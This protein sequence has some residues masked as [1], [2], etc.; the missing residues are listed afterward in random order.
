M[1]KKKIIIISIIA[2]VVIAA[3]AGVLIYFGVQKS[4]NNQAELTTNLETLGKSFY[5]DFYYPHQ[6]QAIE[7][8]NAKLK[9]KETPSTIE[10][11]LKNYEK[12]GI[13]VNLENISK[14]SSVDKNLVDS[15][16]NK[17]TKEKCNF[18]KS[19]VTIKPVAPYGKTD[20]TIEVT[21]DC[22]N[23]K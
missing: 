12:T 17:K 20:Y 1:E 2:A 10:G 21:L 7:Q 13:S 11:L 5:E 3:V 19:K 22:G 15:M 14:V 16:V 9:K 18:E 6:V 4:K 8:K 23:F